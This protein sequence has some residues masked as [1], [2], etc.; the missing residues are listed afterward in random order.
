MLG[1]IIG[2][3]ALAAVA[4]G[5][6]GGLTAPA[7]QVVEAAALIVAAAVAGA[8]L[9]RHAREGRV[10]VVPAAIGIACLL[11]ILV[12]GGYGL[13][14]RFNRSPYLGADPAL[15]VLIREA[16]A[17]KRIAIAGAWTTAPPAPVFPSFG[18]RLG[19][20]VTYAG[21]VIEDMLRRYRDCADL[22]ERLRE[23]RYDLLL[24]GRPGPDRATAEERCAAR[25]RIPELARS[26][27]FALFGPRSDQRPAGRDASPK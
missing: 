12:A 3:V 9:H 16:P 11:A 1:P 24:I 14:K 20:E 8:W 5:L 26:D 25:A 6:G 19:N 22:L 18:S 27:R 21:P 17:G 15:D 23:D 4:N 7:G 10:A 2:V 13:Q